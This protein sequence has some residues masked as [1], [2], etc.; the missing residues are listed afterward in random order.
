M[1]IEKEILEL[2]R[3]SGISLLFFFWTCP[4]A[5]GILVPQPGIKPTPPVLKAQHLNH[6]TTR[7]VQVSLILIPLFSDKHLENQKIKKS[8]IHSLTQV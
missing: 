3:N 2:V 1:Y 5:C 7:E 8:L 6:W 4:M